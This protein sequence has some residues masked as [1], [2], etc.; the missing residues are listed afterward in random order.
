MSDANT[1]LEP[2]PDD[3]FR[4]EAK[5]PDYARHPGKPGAVGPGP[6]RH[7]LRVARADRRLADPASE[8]QPKRVTGRY[9]NSGAAGDSDRPPFLLHV[10]QAGKHIEALLVDLSHAGGTPGYH[11]FGGNLLGGKF[12]VT[13][14]DAN[15]GS[16]KVDGEDLLLDYE[17]VSLAGERFRLRERRATFLDESLE[18]LIEVYGEAGGSAPLARKT[19]EEA[20]RTPLTDAQMRFLSEGLASDWIET[21]L[22]TYH[23]NASSMQTAARAQSVFTADEFDG[24][25]GG[26]VKP[27]RWN[28]QL[29]T[30]RAYARRLLAF[31]KVTIGD[32]RK[33]ALQWIE[34]MTMEAIENLPQISP[35]SAQEHPLTNLRG[36]VGLAPGAVA[37]PNQYRLD[38]SLKHKGV[39]AWETLRAELYYG[40][41]TV[42]S[43]TA[44]SFKRETSHIYNVVLVGGGSLHGKG[45]EAEIKANA[46]FTTLGEWTPADFPG[47]LKLVEGGAWIAK[48]VKGKAHGVGKREAALI[49]VGRGNHPEIIAPLEG[50]GERRDGIGAEFALSYGRVLQKGEKL[51]E[52]DFSRPKRRIDYA[53][54]KTDRSETHFILGSALLRNR[55]TL[56]ASAA[57][58]LPW[59]EST[60]SALKIVGRADTVDTP[61]R[62][63]DLSEMRAKNV[64]Q[65]L[66]DILGDDLAIPDAKVETQGL[67]EVEASR[68][69]P[70]ETP[71]LKYRRVD[72]ELNGRCVLTL[73]SS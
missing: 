21:F 18:P 19:L 71:D 24:R 58:W 45:G 61:K 47:V 8:V 13:D 26:L 41:M 60:E 57:V 48:S 64:K 4:Y 34:D 6:V 10:N 59:L 67:G 62:N 65:A 31:Q 68:H 56:R 51:D 30:A 12:A 25:V 9:Q 7:V 73:W 66:K 49:L 3:Q 42:A 22:R 70:D 16:L 52:K 46:T 14:A 32:S 50:L 55:G 28:N 54:E 35:S 20:E 1:D 69:D 44:T 37:R 39:T 17:A 53:V 36:L 23:E 5:H 27:S 33:S 2:P 38:L 15:G 29:E 40:T 11:R 63:V 43:E 72:V